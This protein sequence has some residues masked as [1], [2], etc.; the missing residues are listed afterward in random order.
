MKFR[1]VTHA[2]PPA[3]IPGFIAPAGGRSAGRHN[4][5][6]SRGGGAADAGRSL[7]CTHCKMT[8]HLVDRCWTKH[9]A[10]RPVR[11]AQAYAGRGGGGG[12]S[13]GG[14]AAGHGAAPVSRAEFDALVSQMSGWAYM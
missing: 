11:F 9:K 12:G 10:L 6:R 8:G 1:L 7:V 4:P 3:V 2:S 13:R 14:P 5:S